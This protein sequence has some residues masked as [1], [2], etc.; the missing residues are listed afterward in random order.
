[1]TYDSHFDP[2]NDQP[3]SDLPVKLSDNEL[4]RMVSGSGTELEPYSPPRDYG[5]DYPEASSG[6]SLR[7]ICYTLFRHKYKVAIIFLVFS[8]LT[9]LFVAAQPDRYQSTAEVHLRMDQPQYG[10][11]G[12]PNAPLVPI[13]ISGN[14][15]RAEIAIISG[16][17]VAEAVVNKVG[18]A[19]LLAPAGA[20]IITSGT[21]TT[22]G[23][24]VASSPTLTT[25]QKAKQLLRKGVLQVKDVLNLSSTTVPPFERAVRMMQTNLSIRETM[26][27]SGVLRLT[28]VAQSPAIV[29]EALSALVEE[30][31]KQH[32][33]VYALRIS[34]EESQQVVDELA[35]SMTAKKKELDQKKLDA[36]ITSA[37][38]QRD[39]LYGQISTFDTSLMQG[40][41][42]VAAY[43]EEIKT[44]QAQLG[45][46]TADDGTS[47]VVASTSTQDREHIQ[48]L[49]SSLQIHEA[50]LL[51]L[52]NIYQETSDFVLDKRRLIKSFED[53]LA[54]YDTAQQETGTVG[55]INN[56]DANA[57]AL[58]Q[59]LMT[60]QATLA[61]QVAQNKVYEADLQR[62][63]TEIT[64]LEASLKIVSD[65][66]EEIAQLDSKHELAQRNLDIVK[67][68]QKNDLENI[69]NVSVSQEATLPYKSLK[70]SKK[71][72]AILAFGIFM[73]LALGVGLAFTLDFFNHTLKT[74]EDVEKWLGLPVLA[75]LPK[76]RKHQPESK[77]IV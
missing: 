34:V 60:A 51:E 45:T 33:E 42:L 64:A 52:L 26:A 16:R 65:L 27:G 5:F 67:N 49:R 59:Q 31:Q 14:R 18:V 56:T 15:V 1:M 72:L 30:Y 57:Q 25:K 58:E 3:Q 53:M 50:Q 19:R 35:E 74:N 13:R 2:H 32:I 10:E 40:K 71:M 69:S 21:A 75:S 63:N 48:S 28:F 66:E 61:A 70:T 38:H 12:D 55:T 47:V 62:L 73:G 4:S 17:K 37:E 9:T 23:G 41:G 8:T 22:G 39:R 20:N 7:D 54:Q 68:R 43:Q 77:V 36:E 11:T 44:L 24:A 29:Q 76:V 6:F 46:R